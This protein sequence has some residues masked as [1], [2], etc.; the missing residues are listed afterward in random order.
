[1]FSDV[2][3]HVKEAIANARIIMDP[4]PHLW[5]ENI[6]PDWYYADM[7]KYAMPTEYLK[8]LKE[9]KRVGDGYPDGRKVMI[10]TR[11][12]VEALPSD[13]KEFWATFTKWL[14][15]GGFGNYIVH[16][17]DR[18]ILERFG[19]PIT[20]TNEGI[21]VRDYTGYSLGPHT[22]A[23]HKVLTMLMYLPKPTDPPGL[24][25]SIYAP[26]NPNFT[27]EGGPH[28][29]FKDYNLVK[30]MPYKANCM[31][32]F[33]KNNKSFHGVEPVNTEDIERNLIIYDA[34]IKRNS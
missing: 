25:T 6:F 19:K 16:K 15:Q 17:F 20:I 21:Y 29:Q 34:R 12:T 30:T 18:L 31:F 13:C 27:C 24:G 11:D 28:H 5:V 3:K 10:L 23:P 33:F 7:L 14:T 26:K 32:G 2:D 9:L 22:D 4:Y 8:S 1:M